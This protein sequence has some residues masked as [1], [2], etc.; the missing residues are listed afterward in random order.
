MKKLIIFLIVVKLLPV[1]AGIT[2]HGQTIT[3]RLLTPTGSVVSFGPNVTLA[4]NTGTETSLLGAV[5]DTIQANTL[6]P[7]RPY[8][9]ELNCI[10]TTPALSLPN[11]TLRIKMG[12][13]TIAMVNATTVSAG[14]TNAGVRIRGT[15]LATSLTT[16]VA[17]TEIIQPNGN[18][19]PLTNTNAIFYTTLTTDMTVPQALDITAQWGGL[20]VLGT[21]S[22]KSVSFYRAD[23]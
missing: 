11:L 16:Q 21:A 12:A 18:V 8:R 22:I 1:H 5:K 7:Y 17:L 2:A 20:I 19:I 15:V 6:V 4:N 13:N 10:L 23:F 14:Q 3:Q 9:F